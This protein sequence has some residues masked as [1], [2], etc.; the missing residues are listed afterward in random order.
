[1][2]VRNE[3]LGRAKESWNMGKSYEAKEAVGIEPPSRRRSLHRLVDLFAS[4]W[5]STVLAVIQLSGRAFFRFAVSAGREIFDFHIDLGCVTE[6]HRKRNSRTSCP[7][8]NAHDQ[9]TL[10]R[11]F[12]LI[13]RSNVGRRRC[14]Q[15]S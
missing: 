9:S 10:A 13:I 3:E 2:L 11:S 6:D 14:S 15:K 4:Y 8:V 7:Q 12:G 1:M 5:Q